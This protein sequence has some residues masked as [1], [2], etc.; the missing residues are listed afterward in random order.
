MGVPVVIVVV[1]AVVAV[2][3]VRHADLGRRNIP[4]PLRLLELNVRL[5]RLRGLVRAARVGVL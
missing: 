2:M 3:G 1:V 5:R 4:D